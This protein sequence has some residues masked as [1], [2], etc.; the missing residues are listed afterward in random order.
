MVFNDDCSACQ[1]WASRLR[2]VDFYQDLRI[3]LG[4]DPRLVGVSE[5][6]PSLWETIP[7]GVDDIP[8]THSADEGV[9]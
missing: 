8:P 6:P 5:T 9:G 2:L 1:R 4:D 3:K 7:P